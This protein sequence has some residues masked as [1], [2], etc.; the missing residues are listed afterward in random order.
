MIDAMTELVHQE[1]YRE[2][3]GSNTHYLAFC[4][5]IDTADILRIVEHQSSVIKASTPPASDKLLKAIDPSAT[6]EQVLRQRLPTLNEAKLHDVLHELQ[7][8]LG[9]R[10]IYLPVRP[11]NAPK[12]GTPAPTSSARTN[13]SLPDDLHASAVTVV[14][15]LLS[16]LELLG[17][18]DDR[19][20]CGGDRLAL[21]ATLLAGQIDLLLDLIP[22]DPT[23][24]RQ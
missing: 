17:S 20:C 1:I 10:L 19:D 15:P 16:L 8:A 18:L 14:Q 3:N 21:F 11:V 2:F 24:P 22:A 6:I 23:Q 12:S 9:G 5:G 13:S 7:S 4:H